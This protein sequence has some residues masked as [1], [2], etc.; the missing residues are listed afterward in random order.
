MQRRADN[1]HQME[2]AQKQMQKSITIP[3]IITFKVVLKS[4]EAST[5]ALQFVY[6]L[7]EGSQ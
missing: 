6:L 2:H 1:I 3:S 4:T 7:I 5:N